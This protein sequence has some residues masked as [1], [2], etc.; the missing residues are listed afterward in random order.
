MR[1]DGNSL[2]I[3]HSLVSLVSLVSLQEL[4]DYSEH[5]PLSCFID[6]KMFTR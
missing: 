3:K 6:I 1:L 2:L 5:Y 4:R